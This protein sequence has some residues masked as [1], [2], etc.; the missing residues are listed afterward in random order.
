M[1]LSDLSTQESMSGSPHFL[2]EE[3]RLDGISHFLEILCDAYGNL[4]TQTKITLS[5]GEL[6]INEE[7]YRHVQMLWIERGPK[8]I[9]PIPEKSHGKR[10]IGRGKTPTIDICFRDWD[11][12]LYFG[13]ECKI[14]EDKK[15]RYNYYVND[16]V[17]R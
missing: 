12:D 9:T 10:T 6:S 4:R 8:T 5:M 2:G 15:S 3:L 16:G 17:C 1:K 13:V 11:P 14:L 7:F